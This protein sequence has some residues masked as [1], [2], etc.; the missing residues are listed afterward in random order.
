MELKPTYKTDCEDCTF[1]GAIMV[2]GKLHDLY[3]TCAGSLSPF[4]LRYG[5]AGMDYISSIDSGDLLHI[6]ERDLGRKGGK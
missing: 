1:V 3:L 6:I 5:D 4:I 2:G